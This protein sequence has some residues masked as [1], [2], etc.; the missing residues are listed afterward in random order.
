MLILNKIRKEPVVTAMAARMIIVVLAGYG[1]ELKEE[2]VIP[3]LAG[4]WGLTEVVSAFIARAHVVP[5]IKLEGK[6]KI[7]ATLKEKIDG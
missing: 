5:T 4:V 2:Q 7:P 1:L 6:T 3:I